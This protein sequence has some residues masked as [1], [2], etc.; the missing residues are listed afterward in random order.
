[1]HVRM[2]GSKTI[3]QKGAL[4]LLPGEQARTMVRSVDHRLHSTFYS[5]DPLQTRRRADNSIEAIS[6]TLDVYLVWL[7]TLGLR[8]QYHPIK[9]PASNHAMTLNVHMG[10][11][12]FLRPNLHQHDMVDSPVRFRGRLTHPHRFTNA[13]VNS[14]VQQKIP[15]A[16]L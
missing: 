16:I 12:P 3:M 1:M 2:I 14:S 4:V 6:T 7:S 5:Y 15:G 8:H 10:K 9:I 11:P 13:A